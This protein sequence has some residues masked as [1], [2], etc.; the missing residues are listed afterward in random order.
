[1]IQIQFF[2]LRSASTKNKS[3]SFVFCTVL[4]RQELPVN[5]DLKKA[6]KPDVGKKVNCMDIHLYQG[7][8]LHQ[9]T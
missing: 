6:A 1:L 4:A 7:I 8:N 5:E 3:D 2:P 9:Y